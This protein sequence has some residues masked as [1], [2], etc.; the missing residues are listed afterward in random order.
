MDADARTL[1]GEQ[2]S[3]ADDRLER[4]TKMSVTRILCDKCGH[5]EA[6]CACKPQ[7]ATSAQ[8]APKQRGPVSRSLRRLVGRWKRPQ[9]HT[10]AR[11]R[12]VGAKWHFCWLPTK[13]AEHNGQHWVML[14][15]SAWLEWVERTDTLWCESYYRRISPN[16]EVRGARQNEGR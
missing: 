5:P 16:M 10:P 1:Q 13:L 3:S 14:S 4:R 8:P 12:G 6:W 15:E 11:N 9:G 7:T 2:F